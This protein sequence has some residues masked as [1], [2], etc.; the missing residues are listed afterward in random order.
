[1]KFP[2]PAGPLSF[3][4]CQ[5]V[6]CRARPFVNLAPKV[7]TAVS[8][9][10]SPKSASVHEKMEKKDPSSVFI[11]PKARNIFHVLAL[12]LPFQITSPPAHTFPLFPP[13]ASQCHFSF[14]GTKPSS[15]S[16]SRLAFARIYPAR[17]W[18]QKS[19]GRRRHSFCRI[20]GART[21]TFASLFIFC[22][23]YGCDMTPDAR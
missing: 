14:C 23:L 15:T 20:F 21:H 9:I 18:R 4:L 12:I 3:F 8:T 6:S 1:M 19:C 16:T 11:L 2:C 13:P 17:K 5:R 10:W 7:A 22:E